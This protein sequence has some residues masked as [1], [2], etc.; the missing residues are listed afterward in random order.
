MSTIALRRVLAH[1]PRRCA[2]RT[3]AS[4]RVGGR[5]GMASDA[6]GAKKSSDTAWLIGS[7]VVTALGAA[8]ILSPP[9]KKPAHSAAK[10]AK[11]PIEHALPP[12][13]KETQKEPQTMKD[14][15]GTEADV[16]ESQ[17]ASFDADSPKDAQESE[18]SGSAEDTRF[19]D[20]APGQ[21]AEVHEEEKP[22]QKEK[23]GKTE[24]TGTLQDKPGPT[25]LGEAR[26]QAK[27][28]GNAPK[29]AAKETEKQSE[30][31]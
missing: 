20:G 12:P 2:Q 17:K 11:A 1:V 24:R 22:E 23:P 26:K 3:S 16:T 19:D 15:E 14:S 21:T 18:E 8:W 13:E 30:S 4:L 25:N 7:G 6:H 10:A 31:S 29:E 5:R 27:E 9:S 28:E